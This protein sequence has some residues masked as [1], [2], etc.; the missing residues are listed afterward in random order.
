ML[1][2][3][4]GTATEVG[5]TFVGA[6]VLRDLRARGRTVSARKP[7]QSFAPEDPH[8]RDA[9]VLA[10]ATGER[11]GDVCSD[12]RSYAVAM[13]PPMAAE[14][15]GRPVPTLA[16][17]LEELV[18]PEP[19]P[20]LR[21]LETVGGPRSPLSGDG[22]AVDLV[23][24]LRPDEVVL[25]ADAGLGTINAVL[26]SIEPF[27]ALGHEPVVVLNWFDA[28]DDLHRR[29]AE[30]LR[31]RGVTVLVSHDAAADHLEHRMH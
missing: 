9:D 1:V 23:D 2:V 19:A 27:R 21:W 15:L 10:E 25:V 18:W 20:E 28:G 24:A 29:N 12:A 11:A 7:A 26:L 5:K 3:C 14:V 16:A 31:E 6:A 30:W 17:L 8:P 22:D 4:V 13:A